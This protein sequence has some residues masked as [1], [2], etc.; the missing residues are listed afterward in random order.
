MTATA[1]G[2]SLA[3]QAIWQTTVA[4]AGF[5]GL[6]FYRLMLGGVGAD[7]LGG[8]GTIAEAASLYIANAP[9]MAATNKYAIR[10]AAGDT[11]L[12][13]LTASGAVILSNASV[14][15]TGAL[16][17]AGGGKRVLCIDAATG[18]ISV[19]A[20]ALDCS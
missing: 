4:S 9:D 12:V 19:S 2:D 13:A 3:G 16:P 10:V 5:T 8:G 18:A 11:S 7:T 6:N 14:S 15:F 1:N 20:G 17:A